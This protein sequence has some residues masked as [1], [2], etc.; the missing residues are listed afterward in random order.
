MTISVLR[1]YMSQG[2]IIQLAC[3]KIWVWKTNGGDRK[4]IRL[5]SPLSFYDTRAVDGG[6]CVTILDHMRGFYSFSNRKEL[7]KSVCKRQKLKITSITVPHHLSFRVFSHTSAKIQFSRT[8][9]IHLVTSSFQIAQS[10]C[11]SGL[12][13][14]LRNKYRFPRKVIYRFFTGGTIPSS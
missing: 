10:K 5:Y 9:A 12:V 14:Q 11:L 1:F 8:R 4:G 6:N 2:Y 3:I 13:S 7:L